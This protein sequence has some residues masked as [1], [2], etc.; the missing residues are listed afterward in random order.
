MSQD[1]QH[2]PRPESSRQA[3]R[4]RGAAGNPRNRFE[5]V[6]LE[7]FDEDLA[8]EERLAPETLFLRDASKSIISYNDSPDVGFNASLNPYRG[9]EHGCSYCY[10]RPTHEYLGFSA[11]LDFETRILVK[12]DA[13]RLLREALASPRWK[14]QALALSGVTDP[15]QPI[16]RRLQLTRRC[17]AVLAECLNPVVMITKN[18]QIT[19]DLDLLAELARRGC[20]NVNI[21]ITTLDAELA[22]RLEPRTSTPRARLEAICRLREAGVPVGVLIAPVI[23]GLT[24]H[25]LPA[26]VKAVADAGA[27]WARYILLRL[28]HGLKELFSDWL[29]RNEPLKRDKVLGRLRAMRGGKLYD[30]RFATRGRGEGSW[31]DQIETLFRV[32]HRRAGLGDPPALSCDAFRRPVVGQMELFGSGW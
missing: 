14:P 20:A 32:A 11:G 7:P 1:P 18:A 21:T 24:D 16:E 17:L 12:E 30:S 15:Y 2:V 22:R 27:G 8:P 26:I 28:P 3:P 4:G 31:A 13:P 19:R 10:A 5:R 29:E 23:P 25:E 6:E 9:C